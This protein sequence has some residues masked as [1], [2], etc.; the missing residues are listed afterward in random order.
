MERGNSEKPE[1]QKIDMDK[2]AV[3][4]NGTILD[5]DFDKALFL[6]ATRGAPILATF[7]SSPRVVTYAS[8]NQTLDKITGH[9]DFS[10]GL[11][12][13]AKELVNDYEFFSEIKI[14]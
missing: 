10:K 9:K 6:N 2:V 8:N 13:L 5:S 1:D 4:M 14:S 3:V 12:R 11:G 7:P